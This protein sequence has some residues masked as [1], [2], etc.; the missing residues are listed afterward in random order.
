MITAQYLVDAVQLTPDMFGSIIDSELSEDE[1]VAQLLE[2]VQ[3]NILEGAQSE[4][5]APLMQATG[6][7][8]VP[9][10]DEV[11]ERRF[12]ALTETQREAINATAT[13]LYDVEVLRFARA[14]LNENVASNSDVYTEESDR[15]F[16][17]ATKSLEKLIAFV[18]DIVFGVSTDNPETIDVSATMPRA[19]V[20]KQRVARWFYSG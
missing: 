8:S 7:Y 3:S 9:L 11:I 5:D 15:S 17:K 18:T 1:Q 14:Q 20:T 13:R 19:S 12:P 4:V 16:D 6:G 10:P 2:H